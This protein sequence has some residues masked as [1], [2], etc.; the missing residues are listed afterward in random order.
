MLNRNI[1]ID[2]HIHS[3][4]SAYKE[5]DGYVDESK[6]ENS[7]EFIK[8]LGFADEIIIKQNKENIEQ[9]VVSIVTKN[10]EI[11]IPFEDLVDIE[12][13]RQRLLKEKEK[14]ETEKSK[15]EKMLSNPG[16]MAKAP[17]Q[18]VEE[19]TEKLAKFN[20]ILKNIEERINAL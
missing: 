20:E 2:L 7:Q 18:K 6:I 4:A 17:K 16:F 9:N 14:I 15:T 5:A 19:E 1:K 3:K 10:M 11:F 8:K 13:E 12:E